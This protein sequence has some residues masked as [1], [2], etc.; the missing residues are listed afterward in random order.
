[1][2]DD[3]RERASIVVVYPDDEERVVGPW[4]SRRIHR[5]LDRLRGRRTLDGRP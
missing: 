4:T 5:L 2:I 3:I 1:M